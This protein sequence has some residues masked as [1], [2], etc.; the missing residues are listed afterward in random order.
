MLSIP[1]L[2]QLTLWWSLVPTASE[3]FAYHEGGGRQMSS[4]V[5]LGH[6][7]AHGGS[8]AGQLGRPFGPLWQ[9]LLRLA[10]HHDDW[11]FHLI[12][13]VSFPRTSARS[14]LWTG[15]ESRNYKLFCL[16]VTIGHCLQVLDFAVV[17]FSLPPFPPWRPSLLLLLL[18]FRV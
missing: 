17:L 1:D 5:S 10:T 9:L 15:D 3:Q 13:A 18:R 16:S 4:S 7:W 11:V 2:T 6:S 14:C 8:L 12:G